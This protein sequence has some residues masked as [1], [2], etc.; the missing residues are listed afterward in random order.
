[1]KL[2]HLM[3]KNDIFVYLYHSG[4]TY[5][6][7]SNIFI[8]R[9]QSMP[10]LHSCADT[11]LIYTTNNATKYPKK[12]SVQKDE[13]LVTPQRYIFIITDLLKLLYLS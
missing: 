6:P 3:K 12:S 11:E 7:I 10:I 4:K 2:K 5:C 1:M 8:Y 13:L 9:I